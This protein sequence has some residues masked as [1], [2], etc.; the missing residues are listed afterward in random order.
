MAGARSS[1]LVDHSIRNFNQPAGLVD[2]L[3]FYLLDFCKSVQVL[4]G[5]NYIIRRVK[6]FDV[7][8]QRINVFYSHSREV[9]GKPHEVRNDKK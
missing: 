9:Y 4:W 6:S 8:M 7:C 3:V 1:E 2:K 5:R